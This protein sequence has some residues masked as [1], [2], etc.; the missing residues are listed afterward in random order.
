MGAAT[1]PRPAAEVNPRLPARRGPI[2]NGPCRVSPP[3]G[4]R[5]PDGGKGSAASGPAWSPACITALRGTVFPA[6]E[7]PVQDGDGSGAGVSL[8]VGARDGSGGP[9]SVTAI[10]NPP[11]QTWQVVAV[12]SSGCG[13]RLSVR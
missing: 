13:A 6:A 10:L 9:G 11:G 5:V 12:A 1:G 4:E 3:G 2:L 8:G 7:R